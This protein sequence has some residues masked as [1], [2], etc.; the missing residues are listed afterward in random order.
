MYTAS[1]RSKCCSTTLESEQNLAM[2][3]VVYIVSDAHVVLVLCDLTV[4]I[5]VLT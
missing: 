5:R 2:W 1:G 3:Y 4:F